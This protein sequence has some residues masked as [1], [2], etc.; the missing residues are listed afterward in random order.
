MSKPRCYG[1]AAVYRVKSDPDKTYC[2]ETFRDTGALVEA[3][4]RKPLTSHAFGKHNGEVWA[5][6]QRKQKFVRRSREFL[7]YLATP[8]PDYALGKI[9]HAG[10]AAALSPHIFAPFT[11]EPPEVQA[12]WQAAAEA[13]IKTVI[14]L[15]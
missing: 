11:H 3:G 2:A 12:A 13:V 9:A 7:Q 1:D 6:E 5:A 8:M 4:R 15:S 14:Q 10:A